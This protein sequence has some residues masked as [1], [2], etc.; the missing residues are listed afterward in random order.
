M[1]NSNFLKILFT[2][3]VFATLLTSCKDDDT[4]NGITEEEAVEIVGSSM[5]SSTGGMVESIEDYSEELVNDIAQNGIC[6]QTYQDTIPFTYNGVRVQANYTFTWLYTIVCNNLSIPTNVSFDATSSG[7]YTSN[8]INS[9]DNS[10]LAMDVSGL[11]LLTPELNFAGTYNRRGSQ[12]IT[13]NS[14]NRSI[15]S[16]FNIT[17]TDVK[18]NKTTF[19]ITSGSGSFTLSGTSGSGAFNH[20]GTIIFNGN[21]SATLTINGNNYTIS[22]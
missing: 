15:E 6:N 3:L 8:R 16:D 19:K 11:E 4:L 20:A 22:L 5:E 9:N 12:D 7:T 14:N 10:S 2:A 18:V 1:T 13:F 17:L 21:S